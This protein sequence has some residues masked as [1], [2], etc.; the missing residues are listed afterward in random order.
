[1]KIWIVSREYAGI[2]EAGGVKDVT[3]SLC[4]TLAKIGQKVTLFIPMYGCTNL[5]KVKMSQKISI[6]EVFVCNK[7]EQIVYK[8][9][10]I[11]KVKIVFVCHQSIEEKRAIYTYTQED[12]VLNPAHK[13]G[14]GHIDAL[15]VDTI[16]Q[17]AVAAYKN[18]CKQ[19]E[20]PDIVHCQD[21]TCA[22]VPAFIN[23]SIPGAKYLVTIHNA[24]P[25]YHHEFESV[26]QALDYTDLPVELLERNINGFK[27][28]PFLIAS[29]YAILTTV[30]PQ[31]SWELMNNRTQTQGLG[32][33]FKERKLMIYG[34]TN[35]IDIK[36]YDPKFKKFSNLP[37]TF[38]PEHGNLSGKF[39]C[40]SYFLEN[41]AKKEVQFIEGLEK[42][43]FI[44]EETGKEIY[45]S[46]HG[47]TVQQKGIDIL[48]QS[49]EKVLEYQ[50]N[51]RFVFIGQGEQKYEK[52]LIGLA[53]RFPGKCVYFRGYNQM[54][55]R[56]ALAVS[57]FFL[58]PSYFEPCGLEDF[59]SQ[60]YG[61][62]PV[63]HAT[64]G[65]KKII[66]SQTGFLFEDNTS[67]MLTVMMLKLISLKLMKF[68]Q[69][70]FMIPESAKY[71]RTNYSW[72]NVVKSNYMWLYKNIAMNK[73]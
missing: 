3:C 18:V 63:A 20:L 61:T 67:D 69:L 11:G 52:I 37:Y 19:T 10:S 36:K 62:I 29:E 2:A 35:G 48:V 55:S 1:M 32:Q 71:V 68:P 33:R 46:Y 21:A 42:H 41:Y 60:I 40:R 24:G 5:A 66:D 58:M 65:L 59:V 53:E 14:F 34:I 51:V 28:E 64:G 47:R 15:F 17:K 45:F 25:G 54:M 57:D 6:T 31:Y 22:L 39:K 38:D 72:E 9:G 50:D 49:A 56:L 7:K 13:Y 70:D 16:F 44:L 12:E 4:E 30:S 23:N 8:S 27:V 43:G 26:D 73:F